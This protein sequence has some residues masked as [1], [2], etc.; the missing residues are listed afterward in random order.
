VAPVGG[1]V[2]GRSKLLKPADF[3]SLP[4]SGTRR[5]VLVRCAE[6]IVPLY[7]RGTVACAGFCV[8][9][10]GLAMARNRTGAGVAKLANAGISHIPGR[11]PLPVR[12][13]PPAPPHTPATKRSC[14]VGRWCLAWSARARFLR[15]LP[16]NGGRGSDSPAS[17]FS[18]ATPPVEPGAGPRAQRREREG[19]RR[20]APPPQAR[21]R[22]RAGRAGRA[23]RSDRGGP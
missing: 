7:A 20:R 6:P 22:L 11:K 1:Q 19:C 4:S 13:R 21:A 8:S 3:G 16:R 5:G 12:I 9:A 15:V 10:F 18:R 2:R 17:V 14:A 23:A